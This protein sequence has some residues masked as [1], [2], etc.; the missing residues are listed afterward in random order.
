M[1]DYGWYCLEATAKMHAIFK[2]LRKTV[3]R[4]KIKLQLNWVLKAPRVQE[5]GG[6]LYA[7]G[8]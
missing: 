7:A 1:Q 8:S 5:A 4:N 6:L 2:V 3:L